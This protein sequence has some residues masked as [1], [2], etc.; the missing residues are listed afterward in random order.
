MAPIIPEDYR[1]VFKP[2]NIS[3][4]RHKLAMTQSDLAALLDVPVN[5]LS[6][7]ETGSTAPDAHALAAIYSVARERDLRPEFFVE[8]DSPMASRLKQSTLV[9]QWDSQNVSPEADLIGTWSTSLK[10]YMLLLFPNL[11]QQ[12]GS[13]YP[14]SVDWDTLQLLQ[15]N[16]FDVRPVRADADRQLIED[17]RRLFD[18]V[19]PAF[20]S[21]NQSVILSALQVNV[22]QGVGPDPEQTA[23][24]LV[25]DD[26]DYADIIRELKRTGAEVFVCGT[27]ECS[28]SLKDAA[29]PDHFIPLWQPYVVVQCMEVAIEMSRSRITKSEFGSRCW[30][31]LNNNEL[32]IFPDDAGFPRSGGYIRVLE[33]L[34]S[35]GLVRV[36]RFRHDPNRISIALCRRYDVISPSVAGIPVMSWGTGVALRRSLGLS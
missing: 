18:L 3:E 7:W 35:N 24:T 26:G 9:V 15:H 29:G 31:L 36:Q 30:Q 23:Y 32:G 17:C 16:G 8:G 33:H 1:Y 34:E 2:Q 27:D 6:R 11:A 21:L 22:R 25:A 28:Q 4:L 12:T 14:R 13:V 20:N 5:T 19:Q 10:Q